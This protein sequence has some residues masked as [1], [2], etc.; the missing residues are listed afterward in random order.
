M[1]FL[2]VVRSVGLLFASDTQCKSDNG[3]SG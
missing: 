2:V 1:F 3:T